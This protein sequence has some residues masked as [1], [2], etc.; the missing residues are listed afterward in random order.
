MKKPYLKTLYLKTLFLILAVIF[1]AGFAIL[2][3]NSIEGIYYLYFF[4]AIVTIAFITL[5]ILFFNLIKQKFNVFI[6]WL[7]KKKRQFK[8]LAYLCW[9][10]NWDVTSWIFNSFVYF[11]EGDYRDSQDSFATNIED[12]PNGKIDIMNVYLYITIYR[13]SNYKNYKNIV[14]NEDSIKLFGS[15]FNNYKF[16]IDPEKR[17]H[18]TP[19]DNGNIKITRL[20][21]KNALYN[22]DNEICHWIINRRKHFGM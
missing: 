1:I 11:Y 15:N 7:N 21:H 12:F 19:T 10:H 3:A 4:I 17:I 22:L 16:K 20:H 13:R 2:F 5:S 9:K 8:K 6:L 14:I 18:I